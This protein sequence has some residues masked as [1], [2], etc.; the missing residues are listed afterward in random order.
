MESIVFILVIDLTNILQFLTL[1]IEVDFQ[2]IIDYI[3][4]NQ[5]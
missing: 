4:H 2:S 3:F 5:N 1:I